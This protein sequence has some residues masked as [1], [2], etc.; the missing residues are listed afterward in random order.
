MRINIEYF[1]LVVFDC[2]W[3]RLVWEIAF[4][5]YKWDILPCFNQNSF[6]S[7]NIGNTLH[8]SLFMFIRTGK[9][10]SYYSTQHGCF[11]RYDILHQSTWFPLFQTDFSSIFCSFPVFLT[12]FFL[13]KAWY[14][15]CRDYTIT[16]W[17]NSL[18]FPVFFQFS[19][20][21]FFRF[22]QNF[23]FSSLDKNFDWKMPSHFSSPS[24]NH[25]CAL[26]VMDLGL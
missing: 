24:G 3:H 10:F 7:V 4:K 16:G 1:T 23:D 25:A 17:Q 14:N 13:F 9:T 22:S 21:I 18:T 20:R 2:I 26:T 5:C 19:S 6:H 15:I 12:S 8:L 11:M